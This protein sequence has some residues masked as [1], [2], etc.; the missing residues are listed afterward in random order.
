M[1]NMTAFTRDARGS[2]SSAPSPHGREPTTTSEFKNM[3]MRSRPP[4]LM[5]QHIPASLRLRTAHIHASWTER[6][7]QRTA[8]SAQ[9][10][11]TS[12]SA[13]TQRSV[14]I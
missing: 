8:Q 7:A 12:H 14:T 13:L 2:R 10:S 11:V 1:R 9:C 3:G 5:Q 4:S 6:S